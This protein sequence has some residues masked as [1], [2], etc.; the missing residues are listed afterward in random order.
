MREIYVANDSHRWP[1]SKGLVIESLLNADVTAAAGVAVA[2]SVE[3][4]LLDHELRV[5]T[6]TQLKSIVVGITREQ[7]GD[8]EAGRVEA[9]TPAFA[10]IVVKGDA[11]ELPFSRG[12][13]ARSLEDVGLSP[14]AAYTVASRV[15][16]R[17]RRAG[18][19]RVD[20]NKVGRATE[21]ILAELYGDEWRL[22]YRF[23][24][25]NRGKLGVMDEAGLVVPFSK[26]ILSQSLLA[27]GVSREYARRVARETQQRLRGDERRTVSREA[28]A[29][30]VETILRRDMGEQMA[31][32]YRL[33]RAI[34]R[35]PKPIVLLLGGVSG[36][37]KSF[38]ASEIAYRLSIAR[39]VSTDSV[40]Q[41]MRA[42]VSP[43]LLP[44]LHASTFNA[45]ETM[46]DPGEACPEHPS[47]EQLIAGFRE[48]VA[49]VS[50]GL[51]AV[52][53][54]SIEE[55]TSVVVEGVHAAPGYLMSEIF[56]DAL[57]VPILVTVPDEEEHR[58]HF[59]SRDQEPGHF[60]PLSRY[61]RY[62]REIRVLHQY[63][64]DLALRTDVPMLH[65]L[66][67]D[68]AADQAVEIVAQRVLSLLGQ[69]TVESG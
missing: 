51:K 46:L 59:E 32:R 56:Q 34:R 33:L 2:R 37:G 39:I 47:E 10:D 25:N 14:R 38:L 57:V 19:T 9:Q 35:P 45:W 7:V 61:L 68:D 18:E 48:Q 22:T 66:S 12:I 27:A 63:L 4:Y 20:S 23:L 55:G 44:T 29:E 42:T 30:T 31:N 40:R 60:R 54:R 15:D 11:G 52:I 65:S 24:R 21:E 49:Q 41:V 26:G 62:F 1:F 28:V 50:V 36:T 3:Q 58:R 8:T 69:E 64:Y 17:L 16:G 43:A 6:P 5:V 13:L 67:L 53:E